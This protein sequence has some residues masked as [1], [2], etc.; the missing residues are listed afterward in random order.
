MLVTA[1]YDGN[2]V[3]VAGYTESDE[4]THVELVLSSNQD[5]IDWGTEQVEACPERPS[6]RSSA[7]CHCIVSL[8]IHSDARTGGTDCP[9]IPESM[10]ALVA[11]G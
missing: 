5:L 8:A 9:S 3:A 2:Q 4:E 10:G 11:G 1:I 7:A 6:P